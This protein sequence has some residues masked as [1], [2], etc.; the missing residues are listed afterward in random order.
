MCSFLVFFQIF[1]TFESSQVIQWPPALKSYIGTF[2]LSQIDL[3]NL[4]AFDCLYR[5]NYFSKFMTKMGMPLCLLAA[6]GVVYGGVAMRYTRRVS[7]ITKRCTKCGDIITAVDATAREAH[8]EEQ[9]DNDEDGGTIVIHTTR[10]L[11]CTAQDDV[12]FDLVQD[13]NL[14]AFRR[15]VYVRILE[16]MFQNKVFKLLFWVLLISYVRC[17]VLIGIWR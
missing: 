5:F 10:H 6:L 14:M 3:L 17:L 2:G 4:I 16:A 7:A 9:A 12:N 15:R 8:L 1:F 13:H 11:S